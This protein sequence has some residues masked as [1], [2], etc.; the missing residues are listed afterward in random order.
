MKF[1]WDPNK[2]T[3]NLRKHGISFE[4]AVTVFKYPLALIFDDEEHSDEEYRE[5][6][7]GI[8]ALSKLL[9]VCFVERYEDVIRII[10]AR[11]ATSQEKKDYE[12]NARFQTP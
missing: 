3:I 1:Q 12:E 7:I 5:I 11:P 4:E 9:L 2:A 10:T 8:S 6:I